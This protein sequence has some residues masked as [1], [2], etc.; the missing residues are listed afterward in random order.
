[1]P[2]SLYKLMHY[3]GIFSMLVVFG[4]ASAHALRDGA[5]ADRRAR[6]GF[7]IAH[8]VSALLILT[9]GF[10]M[11][12]RLGIVQGGLPGW[13][14]VKLAIWLVLAGGIAL[15]Y[16]DR[17]FARLL[18]VAVPLAALAAAATALYKPFSG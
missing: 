9:G 5:R 11:L 13:I 8:G 18:P 3:A 15:P 6:R 12:A 4:L 16:L 7:A 14:L 2:Y 1:M 17:R 10:G